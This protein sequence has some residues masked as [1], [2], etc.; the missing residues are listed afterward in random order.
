M[1]WKKKLLMGV[2]LLLIII[3]LILIFLR[4]NQD[5]APN[6]QK[7]ANQQQQEVVELEPG[8]LGEIG[9]LNGNGN[10]GLNESESQAQLVARSF[11]ER[12]G[13]YSN[14]SDY[15]NFS[16]LRE[17]MTD[18]FAA[19]VFEQYVPQLESRY[20]GQAYYGI[21]TKVISQQTESFNEGEGSAQVLIKTQRQIFDSVSGV[22]QVEYQD[23]QLNLIHEGENWL[24]DSA[25]WQ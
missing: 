25:F 19:W 15:Q 21:E 20:E 24:V 3:L 5:L 23:I 12:F 18:S 6:G 10:V 22:P 16:D 14:Q 17:F 9:R 8:I 13:S 4:Y 7:Q 1:S 2:I 11:V